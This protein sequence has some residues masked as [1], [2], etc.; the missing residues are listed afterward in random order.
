MWKVDV[1]TSYSVRG[2]AVLAVLNLQ[3]LLSQWFYSELQIIGSA[4]SLTPF[5]EK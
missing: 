5:T 1:S 4:W 3:V 2:K